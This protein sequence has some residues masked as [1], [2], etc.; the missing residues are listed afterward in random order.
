MLVHAPPP[1]PGCSAVT[2]LS[3]AT[4]LSCPAKKEVCC[5]RAY[6]R[7]NT[8]GTQNNKQMRSVEHHALLWISG[9]TSTGGVYVWPLGRDLE[10]LH[11]GRVW[12]RSHPLVSTRVT[13]RPLKAALLLY[14]RWSTGSCT[15]ID[16]EGKQSTIM[17][18]SK[19][20]GLSAVA[21]QCHQNHGSACSSTTADVEMG[22]RQVSL[23]LSW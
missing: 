3:A 15:E 12:G 8:G 21:T 9:L 18:T 7:T 23:A 13:N 16:R 19:G 5:C 2:C 6:C 4:L 10:V 17:P 11:L 1:S 14:I 20:T 22:M